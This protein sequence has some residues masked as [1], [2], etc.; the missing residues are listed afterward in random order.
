MHAF[1]ACG[2]SRLVRHDLNSL[3][4]FTTGIRNREPKVTPQSKPACGLQPRVLCFG[5]FKDRDIGVRIF[6]KGEESLVGSFSL[7]LISRQSEHSTE[8]QVRQSAD[9]IR[10]YDTAMIE[11]F[12]KFGRCFCISTAG[13]Q[14]F[15]AHIRGGQATKIKMTEV[16]AVYSQLIVQSG[17]H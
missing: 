5:L 1:L 6:P 12:L 3:R 13:K 15:P 7:G 2:A 9:R 8:L 14:S 10:V 16:E 11:N 17:L 4:R